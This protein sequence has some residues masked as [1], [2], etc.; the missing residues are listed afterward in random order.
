MSSKR[1]CL[2]S[3]INRVTSHTS[4][5]KQFHSWYKHSYPWN[6]QV[7]W[8]H[9]EKSI[10]IQI[11]QLLDVFGIYLKRADGV[12]RFKFRMLSIFLA[13]AHLRS[14]FLGWRESLRPCWWL[15]SSVRSQAGKLFIR[16]YTPTKF[17]MRWNYVDDHYLGVE[18]DGALVNVLSMVALSRLHVDHLPI[19]NSEND[20]NV[21]ITTT[22]IF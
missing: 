22:R 4:L 5:Q 21:A 16:M 14:Q 7:L 6:L 10:K 19:I 9:L 2:I 13:L 8:R 12:F 17:G 11:N 3:K 1:I 18:G 20:Y 15:L